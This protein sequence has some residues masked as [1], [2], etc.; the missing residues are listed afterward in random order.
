MT[1]ETALGHKNWSHQGCSGSCRDVFT[2]QK[3]RGRPSI[4]YIQSSSNKDFSPPQE[5]RRKQLPV[6]PEYKQ[7]KSLFLHPSPMESLTICAGHF[8]TWLS[9][10]WPR[11]KH[12]GMGEGVCVLVPLQYA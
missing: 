2:F 4:F 6:S 7:G 5:R 11:A 12:W 3:V 10:H 1:L 8:T 9:S